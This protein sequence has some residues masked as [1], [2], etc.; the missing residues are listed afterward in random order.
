VI[1]QTRTRTIE[2]GITIF[3]ISGR[4]SLGNTLL[5]IESA[6]RKLIEGGAHKLVID[7]AELTY[8]DSAAIG[9]L[10]GSNGLV[11]QAGGVMRV[12]GAQGLVAKSFAVVHLDRILALDSDVDSCTQALK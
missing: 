4:L 7:L 8:I 6:L 2:P 10:V 3:S 1:N 11:E 5:S 12:C 9:M